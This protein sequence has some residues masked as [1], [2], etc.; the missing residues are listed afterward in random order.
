MSF[1]SRIRRLAG[2]RLRPAPE[3]GAATIDLSS[4]GVARGPFPHYERLRSGGPVQ[5]LPVH[6]CW[7]VLGYDAV[8]EAL[9][10][11]EC[12]SNAPYAPIDTTLLAADPPHHMPV[13][14]LIARHFSSDAL[15]ALQSF[16]AAEAGRLLRPELEAVGGYSLPL[17]RSVAARLI[18]FDED[19]AAQIGLASAAALQTPDPVASLTAVLDRF[20]DS[21]ALFPG[22]ME[23]GGLSDPQARSLVRLLWLAATTTTERVI[24]RSIMTLAADAALRDRIL[25]DR[26]LLAPFIEEMMRLHPP[27]HLVPRLATRAFELGGVEIPQGA[28]V[29]LCLGAANRDP[30]V[31][32]DAA[33]I[34]LDRIGKR[35]FAFGSG[36]HHCVGAPL[37]RGVVAAAIGA[38]LDASND[39]RLLDEPAG[40]PFFASMTALS[41][42]AFR[43]AL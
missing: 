13:R 8:K 41:P 38:M 27:E 37:A 9:A 43:V 39:L 14:R 35:H 15:Q 29:Q 18:G 36:I 5:F 42:Q 31:F 25:A 19:T 21:A 34:R 40:I 10:R 33:E 3:P 30:A 26:F 28:L 2:P 20:A 17:S 7:I 12:L 1:F 11:P 32:E 24:S 6:Q 16:A 23:D 22:L 4:P